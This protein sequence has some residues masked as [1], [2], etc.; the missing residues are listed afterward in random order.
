[1][2]SNGENHGKN[3]GPA[4]SSGNSKLKVCMLTSSNEKQRLGRPKMKI[5]INFNEP[6]DKFDEI[7]RISKLEGMEEVLTPFAN[8]ILELFTSTEG[9]ETESIDEEKE[10]ENTEGFNQ[11]GGTENATDIIKQVLDQIPEE[12]HRLI[13]KPICNFIGEMSEENQIEVFDHLGKLLNGVLYEAI[14]KIDSGKLS[15]LRISKS[16]AKMNFMNTLTEDSKY[17]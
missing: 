3:I 12:D 8:A 5:E 6:F 7:E 11:N 2:S 1:M 10:T 15:L 17:F 14:E 9:S 13:I 4:V 16:I